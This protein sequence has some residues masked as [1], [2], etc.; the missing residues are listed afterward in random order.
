LLWRG[1][2]RRGT[3]LE[4]SSRTATMRGQPVVGAIPTSSAIFGPA[5][6]R[7]ACSEVL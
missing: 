2:D 5:L 4:W 6:I 7:Y 3:C 1:P